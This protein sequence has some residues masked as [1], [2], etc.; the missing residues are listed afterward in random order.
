MMNDTT[1][2]RCRGLGEV[3]SGHASL[4]GIAYRACPDCDGTG[5]DFDAIRDEI[6]DDLDAM[7]ANDAEWADAEH[8]YWASLAA[9]HE[10]DGA[11]F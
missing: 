10:H 3:P 5:L 8:D 7:F 2:E 6:H 4:Y 1:C 9:E 11:P